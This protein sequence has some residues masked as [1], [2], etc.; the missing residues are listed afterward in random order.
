[1]VNDDFLRA[2]QPDAYLINTARGAV[3]DP[4]ALERALKLGWI[5]GAGIDVFEPE[6]LPPGH[7]LLAQARL[8]ATPHTAFSSRE[9]IASLAEQAAQSVVDVLTGR[10]PASVVNQ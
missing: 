9:S 1:M 4:G 3:V 5:A 7:P 2:M 10:T 8:L 6:I